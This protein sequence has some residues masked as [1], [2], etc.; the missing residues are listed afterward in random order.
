[1][2]T[3]RALVAGIVAGVSLAVATFAYAQPFTGM[4]PGGGHGF[5]PGMGMGPGHG[6]MAGVDPATN[7][8]SRLGDLKA[9]LKITSTQEFAWQAFTGAAKQQAASMQAL[10][11]RMQD[12]NA[13]ASGRMD[14]RAQLMQ[15]RSAAMATMTSA[16]N[17]LYTV[18]TPE[19][20]T[21]LDQHPGPMV[22]RGM[23]FTGH[24]G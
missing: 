14:Q 3:T 11:A 4:G 18:L 21:I 12:G 23:P 15:E 7:L 1:M 10:R 17:A 2:K 8:D 9:Q 22:H 20:R 6:P 5:G 24:A 13:T 19:Q 16:F